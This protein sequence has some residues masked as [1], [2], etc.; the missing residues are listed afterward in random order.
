MR[1]GWYVNRLRSMDHAEILHRLREQYRRGVSRRWGDGWQRYAAPPL[2]PV[3][4]GL[5]DDLRAAATPALR[6]ALATVVEDTLAGRFSALGQAW[7]ARDP[8]QLFPSEIWRLDPVSGALWP[9]AEAHSFDI[10]LQPGDGRGDVKYV[11]E[12]HRLQFLPPLSAQWLI[13]GDDR[14]LQAIEAAIE[15]WHAANPPFRGIGWASGIEV[16]LRAISLIVTLDLAGDRLDLEIRR[17]AG[18]ILA[19][20]AYWLPRFPSLFSS[21]NNHFIAELAGRYLIGLALGG[22]VTSSRGLLLAEVK[23]QILPDGAG[24]EQTPSYAAST[25]EIILVCAAAARRGRAPFPSSIEARLAAFATFADWLPPGGDG[26]G[27]NDDSRVLTLGKEADYIRSVAA[28][29]QGFLQLP[30]RAQAPEDF[31][32]LFFGAPPQ[33]AAAPQGL[34]SFEQGGLSVWRG[35]LNGRAVDLVFDHGPLGYLSIA[36]HGHSDALSLT[37]CIEGEPVLVDPGTW[38]YGSGGVWRDWFRSTPAHNTL[39]IDGQSQSLISGPFNWSHKAS[40][41]LVESEAGPRRR[42]Q[43]RHD[44]YLKRFGVL[45]QRSLACDEDAIVVTDQLLGGRHAAEIVFQLSAGL[46][47]SQEGSVVTVSRG[48]RAVLAI[49]FPDAAIAIGAG[50]DRPGQG[51]WVSPGFGLRQPAPRL[52]WHGEVGEDGVSIWLAVA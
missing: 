7:P 10:D 13:A 19:A 8:G 44:G 20:S 43:A 21:A 34:R 40:A 28:A 14:C 11:W 15:S 38:L 9:G 18:E 52:A 17:K 47:A 42:L 51:G 36:A 16:A 49:R 46:T 4:P 33:P 1:I 48:D 27:D 32:A 30:G 5:R 31:R 35:V 25:A 37:L 6:Q 45:H 41:A 23:K 2:R 3:F 26:F 29:V 12:F 50:G 24:A 22:E 39:N